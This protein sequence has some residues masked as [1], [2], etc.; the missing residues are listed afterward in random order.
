MLYCIE[1]KGE[2]EEMC[3]LHHHFDK[4]PTRDEVLQ[5]ILSEDIN[6][7]DNYGKFRYYKVK[8]SC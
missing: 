2:L 3:V 5:Y 8:Y 6:Y 1:V 4:K 7:D